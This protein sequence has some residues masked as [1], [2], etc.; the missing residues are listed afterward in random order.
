MIARRHI[1]IYAYRVCELNAFVTWPVAPTEALESLE[2]LRFLWNGVKI[3]VSD[4]AASVPGGIDTEEDL[5]AVTKL[6]QNL[7]IKQE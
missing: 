3:H 6:L 7:V 5:L 2:Q 1:G 4:S